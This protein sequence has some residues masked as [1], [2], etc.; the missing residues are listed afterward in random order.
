MDRK[1]ADAILEKFITAARQRHL[2]Y[3]YAYLAGYFQ[4][5]IVDLLEQLPPSDCMRELQKFEKETARIERE[6]IVNLL[7]D[8]E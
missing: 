6:A 2:D 3:R 5:A 7:K 8:S 1:S 4:G